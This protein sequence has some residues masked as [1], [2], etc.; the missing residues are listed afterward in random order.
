MALIVSAGDLAPSPLLLAPAYATHG[1]LV[2]VCGACSL[3][4]FLM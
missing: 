4:A 3:P 2:L 1:L